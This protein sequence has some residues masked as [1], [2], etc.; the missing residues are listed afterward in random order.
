MKTE[1]IW[2][3]ISIILLIYS[4]LKEDDIFIIANTG[5]L[6]FNIYQLLRGNKK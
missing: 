4:I 2:G 6:I 1:Y 5:F 3:I